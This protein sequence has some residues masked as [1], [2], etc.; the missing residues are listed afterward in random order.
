MHLPE[1]VSVAGVTELLVLNAADETY[2]PSLFFKGRQLT[3]RKIAIGGQVEMQ[4]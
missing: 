4:A 3:Y 2:L 1:F